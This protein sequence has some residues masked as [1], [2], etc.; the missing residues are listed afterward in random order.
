MIEKEREIWGK[1]EMMCRGHKVSDKMR[2]K[3]IDWMIEVLASYKCK[4]TTWFICVEVMDGYLLKE[5][6][7]ELG[8]KDMHLI[9]VTCMFI[10]SKYEEVH[11]ISISTFHSK[12]AHNKLSCEL[13][14]QQ[15]HFILSTLNFAVHKFSLYEFVLLLINHLQSQNLLSPLILT[16]IHQVSLY[17]SK[18]LYFDLHLLYSTTKNILAAGIIYVSL[19]IIQ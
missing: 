8:N 4:E 19:K 2:G 14:R 15:E 1:A 9:G 5:Q 18:M 10:A 6:E 13:I 11:P 17:L 16:Q 12:I 3:M 7:R